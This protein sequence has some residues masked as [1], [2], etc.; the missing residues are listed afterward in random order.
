MKT[1]IA[2]DGLDGSG[3]STFAR[4]LTVALTEAGANPV[5]FRVDDFRQ[6]VAW[7]TPERE[8][9]LYYETYYDLPQCESC[10]R[11]FVAG[12]DHVAIPVYD[13]AAE[14]VTGTRR[15][16]LVGATVAV[17]E[18]V[19]PLRIPQAA[20]GVLIYLD[21]SEVEIRR[22]ILARDLQKGRTAD[23]IARRI[24]RRYV[25]SQH[26]YLRELAP[27]DRADIVIDNEDPAA[28]RTLRCDLSRVPEP[29]RPALD[30][31][32]KRPEPR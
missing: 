3:K 21:A 32:L 18:G 9:D 27:R 31:L 11:A 28:P 14:K 7:T 29:L 4:R 20:S 1:I 19:F 16:D 26:R 30:R 2:I 12:E 5:L 22:R 13:I 10:L 17:V 24:D 6:P 8:A 23:E 25:P 15:L